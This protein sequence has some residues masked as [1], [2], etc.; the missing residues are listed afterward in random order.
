MKRC[1][2]FQTQLNVKVNYKP[3]ASAQQHTGGGDAQQVDAEGGK[4]QFLIMFVNLYDFFHRTMACMQII[5]V[6]NHIFGDFL[7]ICM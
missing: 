2:F 4:D 7:E 1:C 6:M 5:S 3:P